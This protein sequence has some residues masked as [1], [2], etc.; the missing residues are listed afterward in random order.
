MSHEC[1]SLLISFDASTGIF[2]ERATCSARICL[3]ISK[4]RFIWSNRVTHPGNKRNQERYG[5]CNYQ[6]TAFVKRKYMEIT[7]V[8]N[9][10]PFGIQ[11]ISIRQTDIFFQARSRIHRYCNSFRRYDLPFEQQ[12]VNEIALRKTSDAV[13]HNTFW[14]SWT[15]A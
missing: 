6:F 12:P 5:S 13:Q 3:G 2:I 8:P 1:I 4:C 14:V 9:S 10:Y 15:G 7:I 11:N